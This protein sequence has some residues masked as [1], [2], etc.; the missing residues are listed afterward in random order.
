M[1]LSEAGSK[2]VAL[3]FR[4]KED[5]ARTSKDFEMRGIFTIPFEAIETKCLIASSDLN[6]IVVNADYLIFISRNSVMCSA[7]HIDMRSVK[8][9]IVATGMSTAR[10]LDGMGFDVAF[11]PVV[12]GMGAVLEWLGKESPGR[13]AVLCEKHTKLDSAQLE[14]RGF[15]FD[16]VT[17]YESQARKMAIDSAKVLSATHAALFSPLEVES[18]KLS[19]DADTLAALRKLKAVCLGRKTYESAFSIFDKVILAKRNSIGGM[20][21]EIEGDLN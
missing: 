9:R 19:A 8:A 4:S 16:K 12:G 2:K 7:P 1:S 11:A 5:I 18:L 14:E 6:E 15:S 17:V 3:L 10:L 20:A 13:V 21:D